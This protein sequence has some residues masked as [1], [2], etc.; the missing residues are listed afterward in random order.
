MTEDN[1][2]P[3]R[4][5]KPNT[6]LVL[7]CCKAKL[8][9]GETCKCNNTLPEIKYN[10]CIITYND[11]NA[12][13]VSKRENNDSN[14]K[15]RENIIGAIINNKIPEIYYRF[16]NKWLLLKKEINSYINKLCVSKNID[17]KSQ[18]CIHKAGRKYHYDF[19]ILI[20][21][22]FEF[23]VEF[24]FNAES[25]DDTPQFVSPMN[26][27]KYLESSYEEFY[28]DNY[29]TQ[30]AEKYN[31]KLPN[32]EEYMKTIG[33]NKPDCV[34]EYK[35]KYDCGKN[36]KKNRK[37]TGN[38]EDI[39]FYNEC[40]KNAKESIQ[41]FITNNKLNIDKLT[42]Y[43]LDSQ[44]DKY[45]MLYK[46]GNIYLETINLDNYIIESYEKDIQFQRYIAT[47]KTGKKMKILL[48]WKNGNGIAYPAFQIS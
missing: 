23:N 1:V 9:K 44:K 28:Y 13:K 17:N 8:Y 4:I 15:K 5:K 41:T 30:I 2:K 43:L 21:E 29:V 6:R 22:E 25:V 12:F 35:Q 7:K 31:L 37:Y 33:S 16:S 11:I 40:K 19:K 24:K 47:T 48:R 27:S 42:Q 10:K 46:N 45:Y 36:D 34:S 3:I 14:N 32:K 26:P 38:K 18:K 20:N 39:E